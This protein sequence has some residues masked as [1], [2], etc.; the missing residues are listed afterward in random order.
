MAGKRVSLGT[1]AGEPMPAEMRVPQVAA[2]P[3]KMVDVARV[4]PN[5]LNPRMVDPKSEAVRKIR[6]SIAEIG[7]VQPSTVVT[8]RAFLAIHP[9]HDATIGSA[10]YVQVAGGQRRAAVEELTRAAAEQQPPAPPVLLKVDVDDTLAATR[11]RFLAATLTEN[12]ARENLNPVEEARGVQALVAE[13]GSGKA[14]AEQLGRTPPWV[15]QRLNLLK[16]IPEVHAAIL[17]TDE[18]RRLPLRVVR[19]WHDQSSVWQLGAL[20]DWRRRLEESADPPAP[21]PRRA[22]TERRSQ[23]AVAIRK[24]GETTEKI[25]ESIHAGLP[26]EDYDA[27]VD[28][29]VAL[30][31]DPI[32]RG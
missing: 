17:D 16:L 8:R 27:L 15:T 23:F 20:A 3:P 7:Q 19:D 11:A 13:C 24:L 9:E 6:D 18:T 31:G 30:R 28:R 26:P 14:A 22:P 2:P 25:A 1:L 5:P 32:N 4:A 29:M 21:K 10:D 12:I